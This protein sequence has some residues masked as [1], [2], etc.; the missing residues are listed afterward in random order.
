MITFYA[1]TVADNLVDPHISNRYLHQNINL[2]NDAEQDFTGHAQLDFSVFG[3]I[4]EPVQFL[5]FDKYKSG[6]NVVAIGLH[7]GWT[8]N[9]LTKIKSWFMSNSHRQQ[10][11]TDPNCLILL[12]YSEEGFTTEVFEDLWTW[13]QDNNLI[14]RVLYVSSSY[15]VSGQYREWCRLEHLGENMRAAWY[16]FFPNWLLRDHG[17]LTI[18]T[19]KAKWNNHKRYMC[20]N[21]RPHPHRILLTTLLEYFQVLGQGAVSLPKHFDEKEIVWKPQDWD[22]PYQ[23]NLL[24]Y[25]ANGYLEYLQPSFERLYR[26]LPLIADTEVFSTNYALDLNRDFYQDYP[27]NVISETLFFTTATFASEKIWKPML[28]QQIFFIMAAPGYLK[29]MQ[30]MGFATFD[31]YIDESYDSVLDPLERACEMVA[32]LKSVVELSDLKFQRLLYQCEER[33]IHNKNLLCDK[34]KLEAM[35]NSR[36]ANAIEH[37]WR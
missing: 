10:A 7:G 2:T 34:A 33:V 9:K 24:Q 16:G 25:R 11:W 14:D 36:V 15:N 17:E 4:N 3:Y 23:W 18:A 37:S 21:R 22:I 5:T 13:I 26:Q 32:S 27:I 1:D 30:D 35:I 31:P 20:L 12:D 8:S 29:D 28:M 19:G 6:R